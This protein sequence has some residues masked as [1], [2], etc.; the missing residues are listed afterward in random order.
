VLLVLLANTSANP[1]DQI[2]GFTEPVKT[3]ELAASETGALAELAVNRGDRV[4][5]KQV[6]G[7]LDTEV[8]RAGRAVTQARLES[9][10]KLKAAQIRLARAKENYKKLQQLRDE[11]HGGARELEL[12]KSDYELAQTDLESVN[13]EHHIGSLDIKRIDAE[14]RRRE[15]TSPIDGVV[16]QLNREVGEFV[17]A[18]DPNI[19]TIVDL[20]NLKIRFY[21]P[22]SVVESLDVGQKVP[23]RFVHNG[24]TMLA[25]IDFIA[26]VIDADSNTIQ[27]DLLLNNAAGKLRSGRRCELVMGSQVQRRLTFRRDRSLSEGGQ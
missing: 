14:I 23:I 15:I 4:K 16:S 9:R 18:T 26:P 2:V 11:G 1:N 5:A 6:V 12:A 8:L 10:V 19:L 20:S 13:D 7:S 25:T 21:P 27:V 3:I 22:T 24:Q 17:T